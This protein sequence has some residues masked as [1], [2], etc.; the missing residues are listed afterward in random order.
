MIQI[1]YEDINIVACIKPVGISSESELP[2]MLSEQ[3]GSTIYTIHRLDVPVGGVMIYAK[4]KQAA[5]E[6]SKIIAQGN[7]FEKTYL[8]VCEGIFDEKSGTMEDILF[9]DSRKNKSY[10]VN[11]ERKGTKKAVLE[12]EIIA[13]ASMDEKTISMS[14]ITLKT[15]R[16]HQIRVQ[17][18][19][20]KHPLLG[21]GKYGSKINCDIALFSYRIKVNDLVFK[22]DKPDE[23]PWDI[24]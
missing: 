20:R 8:A 13:E 16:S 23:F 15:G 3:T 9:K 12:Y 5:S 18:S 21:D 24:F 10:V 2:K 17:F 6:F 14:K 11:R 1:L 4:T 7:D 19:S 22:K